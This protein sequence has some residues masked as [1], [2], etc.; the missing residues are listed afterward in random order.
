M[1][2]N[3]PELKKKSESSDQKDGLSPRKINSKFKTN[4]IMILTAKENILH[5]F[6]KRQITVYLQRK[7]ENGTRLVI[8]NTAS[9]ETVEQC[10]QTNERT[11]LGPG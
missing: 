3:V 6:R 8:C 1:E 9:S 11:A 4:L 10:L 7:E 2:D 5:I